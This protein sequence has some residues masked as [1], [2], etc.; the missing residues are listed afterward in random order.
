MLVVLLFVLRCDIS[1]V[2]W[3]HF[4]HFVLWSSTF[5]SCN[6]NDCYRHCVFHPHWIDVLGVKQTKYQLS[7]KKNFQGEE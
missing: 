3:W 6:D 5:H 2:T 7:Y 4:H 1:I